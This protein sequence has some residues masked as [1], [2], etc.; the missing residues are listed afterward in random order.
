MRH[1][2]RVMLLAWWLLVWTQWPPKL[3]GA[4]SFTPSHSC[5]KPSRPWSDDTWAWRRFRDE[6]ERYRRCIEEFVEEQNA[7]MGRHRSAAQDAI[8]EWN[9]F[10]RW[11]LRR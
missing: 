5:S 9:S 1:M 3:V 10:V 8:E 11:E 2:M 6:V 7:A 4:D